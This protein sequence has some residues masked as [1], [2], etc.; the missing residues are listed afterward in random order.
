MAA[1]AVVRKYIEQIAGHAR[2]HGLQGT[3]DL[4][5]RQQW[6]HAFDADLI[7]RGRGALL[8][9]E[10][11]RRQHNEKHESETADHEQPVADGESAEHGCHPFG[12]KFVLI[13]A[14]NNFISDLDLDA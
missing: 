6:R 2:P 13:G 10:T 3:L 7:Q 4:L 5:H 11:H 14:A 1:G 12:G 8:A 9:V